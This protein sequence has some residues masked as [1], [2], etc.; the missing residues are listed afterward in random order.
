MKRFR[1]EQRRHPG[2]DATVHKAVDGQELLA[3][4]RQEIL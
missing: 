4:L 3:A 1:A 2:P